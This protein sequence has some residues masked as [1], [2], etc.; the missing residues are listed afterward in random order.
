MNQNRSDRSPD[1]DLHG[2]KLIERFVR[3]TIK[4]VV[5]TGVEKITEGPES[6]RNLVGDLR[7]PKEIANY[8]LLQVEETKNGLYGAVAKEIR[9]FLMQSN[10]GEELAKALAHLSLEIRTEIRFVPQDVDA[11]AGSRIGHPEV[12]ASVQIKSDRPGSEPPKSGGGR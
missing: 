5:E 10:V 9:N 6:L 11:G 2:R 3:D 7:V 12:R 1:E 4:K 8:L